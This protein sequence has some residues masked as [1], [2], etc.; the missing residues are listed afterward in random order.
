MNIIDA[1]LAALVFDVAAVG[2][3]KVIE[4]AALAEHFVGVGWAVRHHLSP[5]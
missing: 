4:V 1:G 2:G 3:H 5:G